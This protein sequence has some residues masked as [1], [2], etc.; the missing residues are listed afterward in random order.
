MDTVNLPEASDVKRSPFKR[1]FAIA[2]PVL[3]LLLA[4]GLVVV[5]YLGELKLKQADERAILEKQRYESVIDERSVAIQR[6]D[7]RLFA[8]PLAWSVRRWHFP[9]ELR[10]LRRRDS[11]SLGLIAS[12]CVSW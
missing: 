6:S 2:V 12:F 11:N 4:G 5:Y 3:F 7:I 9:E 1:F 10:T 8:V